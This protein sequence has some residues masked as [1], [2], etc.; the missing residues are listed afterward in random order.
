MKNVRLKTNNM[1]IYNNALLC[2][3]QFGN[4]SCFDCSWKQV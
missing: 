1:N 3:H 4:H 2:Y